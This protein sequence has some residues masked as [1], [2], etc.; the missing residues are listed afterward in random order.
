MK[1]RA[2]GTVSNYRLHGEWH[3]LK[4]T[5]CPSGSVSI[6][7]SSFISTI[8]LKNMNSKFSLVNHLDYSTDKCPISTLL[9]LNLHDTAISNAVKRK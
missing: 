4:E 2:I 3:N 6:N 9:S 1:I 8:S 7:C 5:Y